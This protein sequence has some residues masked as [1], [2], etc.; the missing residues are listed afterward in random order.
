MSIDYTPKEV[1]ALMNLVDTY[2]RWT[3]FQT[4]DDRS[5][6]YY[7]PSEWGKCLRLQQ[8]KHLA[9]K[10]YIKVIHKELD[11]T[12]LRLFDKGHGM[13]ARW[14]RYFADMGVLR[15]IWQ[16][17]NKSC[18]MFD[19]T[20]SLKKM[21]TEEIA[22]IMKQGKSRRHGVG[23]KL[24][25]FCPEKCICGCQEFD[26]CETPV[27]DLSL[28][29]RGSCDLIID[30]SRLN[31]NSFDG[32]RRT[33]DLRLLPRDGHVIVGD[34]KTIGKSAWDFQLGRKGPH[35]EYRIQLTV[36]AHILGCDYGVL[37]YENK[38]DSEMKWY[39]VERSDEWW[40]V[41]EWQAKKMR[42]MA[43]HKELP[44]PRYTKDSYSCK[45]CEFMKLCHKSAEWDNPVLDAKRKWFYKCL[46]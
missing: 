29:I 41:I 5:Y 32:V 15:G 16:C 39:K 3:N 17:K 2:K 26:Y 10:G 13:H 31:E 24:G 23:E 8:Y 40:A 37:M 45:N 35:H 20:G 4:K 28:G 12:Q 11:S 42:E 34:M 27:A 30:C 43:A 18:Y 6:E 44:P 36:Y 22:I 33:F 21:S 1:M 14:A 7:H 9:W 38:N 46:L 25:I 19:D